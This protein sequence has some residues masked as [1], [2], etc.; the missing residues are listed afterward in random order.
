MTLILN[1]K[2]YTITLSN[3]SFRGRSPKNLMQTKKQSFRAVGEESLANLSRHSEGVARRIS[4][5]PKPSFR[6]RYLLRLALNG[7][8]PNQIKKRGFRLW[9]VNSHFVRASARL[10]EE[11][12]A[13]DNARPVRDLSLSLKM[14][15]ECPP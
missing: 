9:F 5:K 8:V 3:T 13:R 12:H 11:S 1:G 14:T 10:A 6:G 2:I 4:C 15:T 7:T